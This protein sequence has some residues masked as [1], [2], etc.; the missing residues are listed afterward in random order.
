[1]KLLASCT[2][3]HLRRSVP[4]LTCLALQ[5]L[6]VLP[7][8]LS[9]SHLQA[10]FRL[11]L[12]SSWQLRWSPGG[13]SSSSQNPPTQRRTTTSRDREASAEQLRCNRC[14]CNSLEL[15]KVDAAT[16]GHY[17]S[18]TLE[19]TRPES[20]AQALH[21][22]NSVSLSCVHSLNESE[23]SHLHLAGSEVWSNYR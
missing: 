23:D 21:K 4:R 2:G 11:L 5:Y 12:V 3:K 7:L 1:M 10:S 16:T 20:M 14:D 9:L 17:S 22:L 8:P 6:L 15:A 13:R 18:A 19:E